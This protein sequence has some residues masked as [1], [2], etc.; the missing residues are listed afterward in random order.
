[1]KKIGIVGLGIMGKGIT[2]NFLKNKYDVFVWNRTKSVA[3]TLKNKGAEVCSCPSDVADKSDIVFE[4]TANDESSKH[5][6]TGKNGILEGADKDKILITRKE[7]VEEV[8][9]RASFFSKFFGNN[10]KPKSEYRENEEKDLRSVEWGINDLVVEKGLK[11]TTNAVPAWFY[12]ASIF[13][14]FLF[15]VYI[16]VYATIHFESIAYMNMTI[17]FLFI[18]MVSYFLISAIFFISEK[19]KW[20][21]I[22]PMLFFIGIVSIM[23]YAFKAV[24]TSNL[25]RFSIIY[26]IIVAAVSVY[27]LAIRR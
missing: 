6:W 25:V 18:T 27:V 8:R 20:H 14:A 19:K 12:I 15:T 5:V 10:A 26:T 2:E 4:V 17:V 23:I 3:N 22:G 7:V 9:D 16:S 11:K 21:A 1:M 13:A 24:D